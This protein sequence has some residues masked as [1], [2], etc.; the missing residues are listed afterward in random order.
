MKNNVFLK[1]K[2]IDEDDLDIYRLVDSADEAWSIISKLIKDHKLHRGEY[3]K[4]VTK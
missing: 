4:I 1:Y 3:H 2:A